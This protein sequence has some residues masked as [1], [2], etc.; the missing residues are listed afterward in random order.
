M[1]S[2]S[3]ISA[4]GGLIVPP[5]YSL[6]K[7]WVGKKSDSPT[8]TLNTLATTNPSQMSSYMSSL[9]TWLSAKVKFFNRDVVG[10]PSQ[11]VVDLR[12]SIRPVYIVSYIIMMFFSVYF[13][14]KID[15]AFSALGNS[16]VSFW[17][18]NR[19]IS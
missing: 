6:I 18:S 3:A 4:L 15:P 10:T 5:I 17:F 11:W 13:G 2:I 14:Y 8:D 16:C 1:L 7:G 19:M 9:A 12:A